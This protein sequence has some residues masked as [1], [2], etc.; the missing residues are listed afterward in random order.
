MDRKKEFDV[1]RKSLGTIDLSKEGRLRCISTGVVAIDLATGGGI[2]EGRFTEVFGEWQSGKSLLMYQ[3]I[4]Q[5]QR[6]GGVA[7]LFDSE[8]AFDVRWGANLGININELLLF[9]PESLEDAFS[10]MEKAI[11]AVRS[12]AFKDSPVLIVYDSLAA[13]VAEAELKQTFGQPEMALRARVISSALRKMT[14][15]IADYRVALV[16][17]NQLRSKIGVMFGPTSDTTGGRAPKFYA[18]LR[19]EMRKKNRIKKDDNIVG[20]SGEMEVVKSK[21]GVP[22]RRVEFDLFFDKGIDRLSGLL[23]YLV[24]YGI[25][26]QSGAWFQF[27]SKKF[28][29]SQFEN[30]WSEIGQDVMD[31]YKGLTE[32]PVMVDV[33]AD[34]EKLREDSDDGE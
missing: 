30:V 31:V 32:V 25:I 14:N 8:R 7:I 2:P 21:I 19:M 20:V 29:S 26:K 17:V 24:R 18:T 23:D 9:T 33:D 3:T 11:K 10:G 28:R 12:G 1:L 6:S 22:F 5:C 15:L 13:S 34:D 4:V 27:G 16:F